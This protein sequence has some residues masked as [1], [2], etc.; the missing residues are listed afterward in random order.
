MSRSPHRRFAPLA[1]CAALLAGPS[2]CATGSGDA[3]P[4][5]GRDARIPAS[6]DLGPLDAGRDDLGVDAGP[7]DLGA[8]DAAAGDAGLL[9][10]DAGDA[11]AGDAGAG[12]AGSSD[13]G[14]SDA[15]RPDLGVPDAGAPDLGAPPG[16][17]HTITIDGIDDF[18]AVDRLATT[19]GSY[20]A[21][22]S[23]DADALYV[24]MTGADVGSGSATRWWLVFVDTNGV[25]AGS[26]TGVPYN[27]QT[28][29]LPPGFFADYAFRWKANNLFQSL[30]RWNGSAWEETATV[31]ETFQTGTFVETRIA[32]TDLGSPTNLGVTML[33]LNEAAGGE[34]S[35]AGT[36]SGT[37]TDGYY[38]SIPMSRWVAVDLTLAAP[39]NDPSRLRP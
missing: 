4:D 28:P 30:Q 29:R 18:A 37:F 7:G 10:P 2:G 24:G 9:G 14:T 20:S 11:G 38:G 3:P 33:M 25:S 15:G 23:W 12:D 34:F 16:Y 19:T 1:L 35:Y 8:P 31:P 26:N 27:T 21:R 32:L 6:P 5:L 13:L 22:L 17:R 36:P 39:P